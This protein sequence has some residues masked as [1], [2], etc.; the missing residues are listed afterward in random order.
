MKSA[1]N[2]SCNGNSAIW[3]KLGKKKISP[4][5]IARTQILYDLLQC[6]GLGLLV[7]TIQFT[8]NY[9]TLPSCHL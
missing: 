9:I 3:K 2:F 7:V 5:M 1:C 6:L 4:A 8:F